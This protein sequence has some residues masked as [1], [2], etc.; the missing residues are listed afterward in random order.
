MTNYNNNNSNHLQSSTS[1][2]IV[3]K[4]TLRIDVHKMGS[5]YNPSPM[6]KEYQRIEELE[7]RVRVLEQRP[8]DENE[9]ILTIVEVLIR[10][11]HRHS[12]TDSE[13][14]PLLRTFSRLFRELGLVSQNSQI[15]KD[16]EE[17]LKRV[18]PQHLEGREI[19]QVKREVNIKKEPDDEKRMIKEQLEVGEIP[20]VKGEI[21]VKKEP[22]D[23]TD[24]PPPPPPL[25][26]IPAKR[27]SD[28]AAWMS[29]PRPA[30]RSLPSPRHSD[31]L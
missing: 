17:N 15:Q 24:M 21:N 8:R 19:P 26:G 30:R 29:S 27:K 16:P 1:R 28:E 9:T 31:Q 2:I 7:A 13:L 18:I 25:R 14:T 20:Q 12:S 5:E 3:L 22:K 23:W 11:I 4:Q 10:H 6:S